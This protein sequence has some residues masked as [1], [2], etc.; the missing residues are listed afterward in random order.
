MLGLQNFG[1][2]IT[3]AIKFESRDK[4]CCWRHGLTLRRQNVYLK[5]LLSQD[6]LE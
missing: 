6:G 5:I 1:D 3:S 2:M 4:F